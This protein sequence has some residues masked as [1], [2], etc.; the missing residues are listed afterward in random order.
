MRCKHI[1]SN[2][3]SNTPKITLNKVFSRLIKKTYLLVYFVNHS[4]YINACTNFNCILQT[5]GFNIVFVQTNL[6]TN[7]SFPTISNLGEISGWTKIHL[8]P[9]I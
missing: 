5:N 1:L 3:P 8:S 4:D 6:E 9:T 7:F 2:F